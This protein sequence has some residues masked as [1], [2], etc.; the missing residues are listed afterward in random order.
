MNTE[1]LHCPANIE[2][3]LWC[4]TRC[5]RHWSVALGMKE[6]GETWKRAIDKLVSCG[7]IEPDKEND[8]MWRTT[9]LGC[10]WVSALCN[11]KI[12][13]TVFVDEQDRIV[14]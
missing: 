1:T 4:H 3:L 12:P 11:V 6:A 9:P 8:L 7:A 14:K 13:R 2:F 5:E 10:A